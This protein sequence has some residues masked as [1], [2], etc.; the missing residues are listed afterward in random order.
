M[1]QENPCIKCGA[2]CAYFRVSFYWGE[3]T[4]SVE[5]TIPTDLSQDITPFYKCMKG[6]DQKHPFC[7]ALQGEVGMQ[8]QC[9]IYELRSSACRDFGIHWDHGFIDADSEEINRCNKARAVWGLPKLEI[10]IPRFEYQQPEVTGRFR[11]LV[12]PQVIRK[13]P[14]GGRKAGGSSQQLK[15]P[16]V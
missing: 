2:C 6:T 13:G 4:E 15:P 1:W 14:R 9:N 8:V 12:Y 16:V 10:S 11:K 5:G 3:T 7:I